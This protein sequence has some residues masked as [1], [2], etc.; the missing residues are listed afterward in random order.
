MGASERGLLQAVEDGIEGVEKGGI[1]S[2]FLRG[3]YRKE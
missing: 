1:E 2:S 3:T